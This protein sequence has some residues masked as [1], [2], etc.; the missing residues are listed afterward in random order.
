[1]TAY[2]VMNSGK[3]WNP[4]F[5]QVWLVLNSASSTCSFI[6]DNYRTNFWADAVELFRQHYFVPIQQKW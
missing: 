2:S 5:E 4:V 3:N 1:M 6:S